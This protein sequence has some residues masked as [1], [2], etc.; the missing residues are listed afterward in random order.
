MKK[1]VGRKRKLL[2]KKNKIWGE[3]SPLFIEKF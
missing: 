1:F 2:I 3:Q